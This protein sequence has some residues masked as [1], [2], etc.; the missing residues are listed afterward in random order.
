M[1]IDQL[2]NSDRT[3]AL[4]LLKEWVASAHRRQIG[5]TQ[6]LGCGW[7]SLVQVLQHA[8][9]LKGS[10]QE[11]ER[12]LRQHLV[13]SYVA[14]TA[15]GRLSVIKAKIAYDGAFVQLLGDDAEEVGLRWEW[16]L[17]CL[18][19]CTNDVSEDR[20]VRFD[21]DMVDMQV[22]SSRLQVPIFVTQL[23][24]APL[25]IKPTMAGNRERPIHLLHHRGLWAPVLGVLVRQHEVDSM[26]NSVVQ[27]EGNEWSAQV[28][29]YHGSG[30]SRAG[31]VLDYDAEE[32]R[33]LVDAGGRRGFATI[34]NLG[35]VL[36]TINNNEAAPPEEHDRE[37]GREPRRRDPGRMPLRGIP[38][39][40][41]EW[42]LLTDFVRREARKRLEQM[43]QQMKGRSTVGSQLK[44]LASRGEDVPKIPERPAA[45]ASTKPASGPAPVDVDAPAVLPFPWELFKPTPQAS[46]RLS[47]AV[48]IERVEEGCE[49]S[50]YAVRNFSYKMP[51]LLTLNVGDEVELV[52]I[53]KQ[54]AYALQRRRASGPGVPLPG[55]G[56]RPKEGWCPLDCLT[57]WEARQ[58]VNPGAGC[59]DLLVLEE[60]ETLLLTGRYE[61][62]REGWGYGMRWGEKRGVG[63]FELRHVEPQV[64]V[65]SWTWEL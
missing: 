33:Y 19:V 60:G 48:A 25:L 21:L 53:G 45:V 22:L 40:S 46:L 36:Y 65:K 11:V 51:G 24:T 62:A 30:V 61:G 43:M 42:H 7:S 47:L 41:L 59:R 37:P 29:Y 64:L 12:S 1:D 4:D 16:Y 2:D 49:I 44:L 31:C 58:S 6:P 34:G 15:A 3:I 32:D 38:N 17:Y 14:Q 5:K 23:L 8:G 54:W 55:S 39:D 52:E 28:D 57:V 18:T 10:P 20:V 50:V 13:T 9:L 27:L 56:N 26:V 35:R 63:S